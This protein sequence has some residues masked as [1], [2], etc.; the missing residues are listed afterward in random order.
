MSD[1]S[2]KWTSSQSM[3]LDLCF[4]RWETVPLLIFYEL[5][6]WSDANHLANADTLVSMVIATAAAAASE[7][8]TLRPDRIMYIIIILLLQTVHEF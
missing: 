4:H 3:K 1:C 8:T 6:N 7:A 2:C 5:I